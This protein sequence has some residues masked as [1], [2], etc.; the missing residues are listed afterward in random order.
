MAHI[1]PIND[2]NNLISLMTENLSNHF[3]N[4]ESKAPN[5]GFLNPQKNGGMQTMMN[6]GWMMMA[7]GRKILKEMEEL[8]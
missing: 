7:R 1:Y 6:H 8:A 2:C 3:V 5:L 4:I